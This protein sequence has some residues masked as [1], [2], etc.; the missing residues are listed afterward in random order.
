MVSKLNRRS[1]LASLAAGG[2][3]LGMAVQAAEPDADAALLA[4]LAAPPV[5]GLLLVEVYAGSVAEGARLRPGDILTAYGAKQP[6][7]ITEL[8]AAISAS[9]K[10]KLV[11]LAYR[12]GKAT[13]T[14]K[15]KPGLL[16]V[17]AV[18]VTAGKSIRPRAATAF[19]PDLS[20]LHPGTLW[21]AFEWKGKHVGFERRSLSLDQNSVRIDHVVRFKTPEFEERLRMR[22]DLL[23]QPGLPFDA[24][25]L[26]SGDQDVTR[27]QRIGPILTGSARLRGVERSITQEA[28]SDLLPT[29][30][31][32]LVATTLP[33][34][35]GACLR[36]T[37]LSEGSARPERFCELYCAG[38]QVLKLDGKD[39]ATH[40]FEA[41]RLGQVR[42]KYWLDESGRL[43][44]A[45]YGGPVA[46]LRD[47]AAALRGLP[48][49]LKLDVP[50]PAPGVPAEKS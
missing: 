10:G 49:A 19:S 31:L 7:S 23:R 4:I 12:R 29:W 11:T 32:D 17:D 48:V 21:Y 6:R 18:P 25:L 45:D 30:A 43:V 50:A 33:Q 14:A 27:L 13:G 3:P 42:G 8:R 28:P 38:P 15:V 5:N 9:P 46:V 2:G 47:E 16:G 37:S 36:Y 24:I 34:R 22:M 1:L 44:R 40:R 41:A 26:E 39:V 35:R 20:R